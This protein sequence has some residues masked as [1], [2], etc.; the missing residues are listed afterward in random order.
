MTRTIAPTYYTGDQDNGG[1]HTNS[2]INNKAAYLMAAGGTFNGVTVAALG[3]TKAAKIYYEAQTQLLTLG[4]DYPDLYN[5]LYQACQNLIG[6]SGITSGDCTEV[7]DATDAVEMNLEPVAGFT[8]QATLCAVGGEVPLNIVLH[9]FET[10][11]TGW[12][13]S[14]ANAWARTRDYSTSGQY[15]LYAAGSTTVADKR[16]VV[17]VIVPAGTS[18]LHF[19]QDFGFEA[20]A[21]GNYDAGVIEYCT[22]GAA[23]CSISSST[24]WLDAS[25]LFDAGAA[26]G[27]KYGGA[28]FSGSGNP[29]AG[30]QAYVGSSHG[31]VSTRL[32]LSTVANQTVRFRWRAASDSS[33][34]SLAWF[35][36]D[37]RLYSTC[38]STSAVGYLAASHASVNFGSTSVGQPATAQTITFTN[39]DDDPLTLSA[40]NAVALSGTNPGD[41][42]IT[43]GTCA[44]NLTLVQ[45]A[46]CTVTIGFTPSANGTRSANV[47]VTSS[48]TNSPVSVP[49]SG[50][51]A[52]PAVTVS[53]T[54]AAAAEAGADPG[55]F[56]ITRAG[57]TT[58]ALTVNYSPG[59]TA[60]N[61]VD[62]TMPGGSVVIGAGSSTATVTVTPVDDAIFE[63]SQTVVL[64]LTANAAYT[65]GA[66]SSATV[67][68]A[69]NDTPPPGSGGGGRGGGGCFIA[70]AAY[71]TPMAGEVRYL[72]AFR[73]QYLQTNEAGRWFVQQYYKY[74]PPVADYLREHDELR[75]LARTALGPL[76]GLSKA[77]VSD[78]AFS[79][80]TADRP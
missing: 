70:T 23:N 7:R 48:A 61:G 18:Y 2:G 58:S 67:T 71:G 43:G 40:A 60:T 32:N 69:D 19:R 68:I 24:N 4:S 42:S 52:P 79:A 36:D 38:Y 74:S 21:G 55:T 22:A 20:D 33:V 56:T 78:G 77:V 27:K 59:G 57:P 66:P 30:R 16:A 45:N 8:P 1:V 5:A 14:P 13:F 41:F 28:V 25:A 73:D 37:V 62:Y 35:V 75:A 64:N 17:E 3:I 72:R 39:V 47:V 10:N 44:N 11:T 29:L 12:T 31:F 49:L 53:A 34:E 65:V 50:T 76:V 80:Q 15:A 26:G 54:D 46:S 63:G 9:D 6:T 51:G